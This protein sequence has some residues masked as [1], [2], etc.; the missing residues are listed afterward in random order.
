MLKSTEMKMIEMPVR[1]GDWLGEFEAWLEDNGRSPKTLNSYKSDIHI[2]SEWFKSVNGEEFTPDLLNRTDVK[3]F[4]DYCS[5][6]KHAA[7]T[8]NRRRSCLRMVSEWAIC[9]GILPE[10]Y[11][12]LD[13]VTVQKKAKT[14]P[15]WLEPTEYSKLMRQV[16]IAIVAANTPKRR[17]LALRDAAMIG[18][19]VYAGLRVDEL[20]RLE[21][22][23]IELSDRKG[24]ITVFHGK[25]DKE[26]WVPLN[27]ESRKYLE[28]WL[29]VRFYDNDLVFGG[30]TVRMIQCRVED[31]RKDCR[32]DELTPHVLRHTCAKRMLDGGANLTEI[33]A[34]LGHEK[35]ETTCRYVQPGKADLE[36]AVEAAR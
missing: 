25:R 28:A 31:I 9:A 30:V 32:L 4:K 12:P 8:W 5:K 34:I 17:V 16:D 2:F 20:A 36:R 6:N 14:L 24:G 27:K 29:K 35:I 21:L 3:A 23:D 10:G 19:M 18:I 7:S 26:R 22:G 13:G 1:T 15:R 33:Q 11:D